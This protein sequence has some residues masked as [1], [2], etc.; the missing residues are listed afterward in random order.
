MGKSEAGKS[1][2]AGRTFQ[3]AGA[4]NMCREVVVPLR[5]QQHRH[6]PAEVPMV[7]MGYERPSLGVG[8][9][10]GLE[11]ETGPWS[12]KELGFFLKKLLNGCKHRQ[13]KTDE[14]FRKLFW[15]QPVPPRPWL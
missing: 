3:S 5:K 6:I 9:N 2:S 14:N 1:G 13:M 12:V 4:E 11:P 10:G 7:P 15:L 8:L